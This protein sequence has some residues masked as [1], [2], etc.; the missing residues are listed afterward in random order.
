MFAR[1]GIPLTGLLLALTGIAVPGNGQVASA[2]EPVAAVILMYHRFDAPDTPASNTDIALLRDQIALLKSLKANVVPLRHA[3]EAMNSGRPLP[4]R[5]VAI[6][7]DD[8]WKSFGRKAWPLFQAAGMPVTLFVASEPLEDRA[9]AYLSWEDLRG[10][11]AEAERGG[12]RL[13]AGLHSHGHGHWPKT[14]RQAKAADLARNR[15][16][17][18]Q[19]LGITADL[20]AYP[21]GEAGPE[22]RALVRDA[23]L[24]A[25]FGQHSGV[26][27]SGLDRF[28]LPRFPINNRYGR[29][30]RFRTLINALPLPWTGIRPDPGWLQ[31]NPPALGFSL[32]ASLERLGELVCYGPGGETMTPEPES[33]AKNGRVTVTARAKQAFAPGRARINCTLPAGGGRYRWGGLQ[34]LV[35]SPAAE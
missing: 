4:D 32:P 17:F 29:K 25:A 33:P 10:M 7:V 21:Y 14:A 20:F 6:T 35:K 16:V 18:R 8:A 2:S 1:F 15:A 5:T 13:D 34:Y 24:T 22:D 12:P 19:R 23:G 3:V 30:D 11:M 9:G 27:H 26:A 28:F 31:R